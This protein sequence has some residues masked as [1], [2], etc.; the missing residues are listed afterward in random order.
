MEHPEMSPV[1]AKDVLLAL[2]A[3]LLLVALV[4]LSWGR[5]G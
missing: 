2:A 4:A 3:A 1:R 5:T